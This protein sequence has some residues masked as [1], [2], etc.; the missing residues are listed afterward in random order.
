MNSKGFLSTSYSARLSS[1][2]SPFRKAKTSTP[3]SS[4][5]SPHKAP[6]GERF[7]PNPLSQSIAHTGKNTSLSKSTSAVRRRLLFED[8]DDDDDSAESGKCFRVTS[9]SVDHHGPPL[10]CDEFVIGSENDPVTDYENLCDVLIYHEVF[11]KDHKS[12]SDAP[13]GQ[14]RTL[15]SEIPSLEL[16][17]SSS[18]KELLTSSE[19]DSGDSV[20]LPSD[21]SFFSHGPV[22]E[23]TMMAISAAYARPRRV[24][25]ATPEKVLYAPG[26]VNDFY[27]NPLSWSRDNIVAITLEGGVHILNVETSVSS[28]VTFSNSFETSLGFSPSDPSTL[29]VGTDRGNVTL[30]D[31][32]DPSSPCPLESWDIDPNDVVEALEWSPSGNSLACGTKNGLIGLLDSRESNSPVHLFDANSKSS[33]R[34][35]ICGLKWN[36]QG[37]LIASGDGDGIVTIWDVRDYSSPL[38]VFAGHKST[39][40]ALAWSPHAHGQLVSGGGTADKTIR[41][42]DTNS[43][44]SL[45][46]INVGSQVCGLHWSSLANEIVS[47]H[48]FS[49]NH[50][51]IWDAKTRGCVAVLCGHTSRIL[52]L[53]V[54]PD[55]RKILTGSPD[56][57]LCFWNLYPSAPASLSESFR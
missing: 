21:K 31:I 29:A 1:P 35:D 40:R 5:S 39:V 54:S 53:A 3:P 14:K 46:K 15:F 55:E 41:F 13:L 17:E 16:S 34:R 4:P 12:A 26:I 11:G 9:S 6:A 38:K 43:L 57:R 20:R 22:S 10:S 51:K 50:V 33:S 18:S 30:Y 52:N 56:E 27:L 7:V 24:I 47:T 44:S 42:W 23:E 25:P 48:G 2:T 37:T 36:P 28:D 45:G 32:R 8:S 49:Q 19:T